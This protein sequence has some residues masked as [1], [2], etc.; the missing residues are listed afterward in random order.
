M[1]DLLDYIL[2]ALVNTPDSVKINESIQDGIINLNL[3]V[4]P[5]DMGMVIGK[6]GQTIRSIRKLVTARAMAENDNPKVYVHL[7]EVPQ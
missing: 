3:S 5:E 1:T 7:Q 2:K 6:N 4:S